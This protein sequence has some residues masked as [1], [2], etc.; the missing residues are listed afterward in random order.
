MDVL[1]AVAVSMLSVSRLKAALVYNALRQSQPDAGLDALLHALKVPAAE[2]R[3]LAD[4]ALAAA[5]EALACAAS[6]GIAAIPWFDG[7]YPALLACTSDMPPVLWASGTLAV[8]EGPA[9]AIVGSRVATPYAIQVARRLAAE[10]ADRGVVVVSGLARGVDSAAHEGC[11]EGGGATIAVLGS[12]VD[13][14]YPVEHLGL[15]RRIAAKG[16]LISE[17]G[18]GAPPLA[19]HFPLRN[20]II[21]GI[22]LGTVVVEASEKS[23]SL[24]TAGCAMRQGR[25]VMA[26]PGNILSGRNRGSHGL[27]KDGAKIVE[28]ADDILDELGWA[29]P[30]PGR[31]HSRKSLSDDPLL[32]RMQAGEPYGLDDL[33]EMTGMA[34]SKLLPRLMELQ[35]RGAIDAPS[36]GRFMRVS[37]GFW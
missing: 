10:L 19:E 2:A 31:L 36:A 21:S 14:I 25:D 26:V 29:A 16:V 28:T 5:T 8:L 13:R 7:R 30:T 3:V 23:G 17:L 24:I 11:L 32:S 9:V 37:R 4:A 22:S 27:L 12:G 1:V 20:R 34:A 15:S 6:L 18:P 35:L 33:V